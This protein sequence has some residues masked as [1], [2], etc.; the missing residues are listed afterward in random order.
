MF[1]WTALEL[2]H[3]RAPDIGAPG[4]RKLVEAY[5]PDAEGQPR[6]ADLAHRFIV[7]DA[8]ERERV[9]EQARRQG[10]PMTHLL[11]F[12]VPRVLEL[13]E[14]WVDALLESEQDLSDNT[15]E[16]CLAR[17]L[18]SP[19]LPDLDFTCQRFAMML[20]RQGDGTDSEG[21]TSLMLICTQHPQLLKCDWALELVA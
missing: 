12:H 4:F 15:G 7:G 5:E 17:L 18:A 19:R 16:S 6:P 8:F 3:A 10:T 20:W 21:R 9:Q 11:L 13:C 2:Y 14:P 1:S